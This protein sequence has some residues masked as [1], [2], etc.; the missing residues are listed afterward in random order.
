MSLTVVFT[1]IGIVSPILG[2]LAGI[3][4][5]DRAARRRYSIPCSLCGQPTSRPYPNDGRYRPTHCDDCKPE[6]ARRLALIAY[7]E[8]PT[9]Q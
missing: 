9:R 7:R 3:A 2:F 8:E 5:A 4:T 6:L 1:L